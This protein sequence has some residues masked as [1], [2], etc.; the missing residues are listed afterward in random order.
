MRQREGLL[1]LAFNIWTASEEEQMICRTLSCLLHFLLM[2]SFNSFSQNKHWSTAKSTQNLIIFQPRHHR[3]RN[4]SFLFMCNHELL[5][6]NINLDKQSYIIYPVTGLQQH[7]AS[8]SDTQH[9]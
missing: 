7:I 9:V 5:P 3:H 6:N 8:L 4:G 2:P 1:F